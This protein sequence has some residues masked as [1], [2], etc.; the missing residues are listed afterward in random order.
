MPYPVLLG[1]K[2]LKQHNPSV[3]WARGHLSLS[4]CGANHDFPVTAF[5]RGYSLVTPGA[6]SDSPLVGSVGLGQRLNNKPPSVIMKVLAAHRAKAPPPFPN[7]TS[8]NAGSTASILRPPIR[9]GLSRAELKSIWSCPPPPTFGPRNK[10]LHIACV[11][12]Q[13]FRKYAKTQPASLIWYTS[14]DELEVRINALSLPPSSRVDPEM[15]PPEPPP[16]HFDHR[17]A[18]TDAPPAI[19][20][21]DAPPPEPPPIPKLDNRAFIRDTA[22]EVLNLVPEKYHSYLD[23]FDPVEVLKLPEHRPYD[24]AID[25]EEGKTPPFGPIYSLAQDERQILFKYIEEQLQKGYIRRSTSSAASPILFIRRKTGDL[26]L[27]IDYRGLNA[28]TKKNRYPLP[29]TADLLDRVQGCTT[30]TVLDLKNAFNL[31]RIKEGDEWKTAFRTHLGL[32]EYTVMPFGLTNAPA[33][34][35]AFIQDALRDILDISVVVYLDDILIFSRENQDHTALVCQV[36]ERLR[37]ANVFLNAKKCEFDRSQVEYLGFIIS[38]KGVQMNP[39]KLDTISKWPIPKTA[40]QIQQF[41]GFTNFYR[42]FVHRYAEICL[43]LT[44]LTTNECKKSFPGL[45][46]DALAAFEQLKLIFTTAPVLRHFDPTLPST[47]VTDASDYALASVHLQ[48]DSEGLLHPVAYYSRKFAPSEI[49]YEIHDK[50]LLAIVECFRDM[51]SWLVGSPHPITVISDHSNL[52]YFMTTRLLNHRQARWSM[53]L[54]EFDFKLDY[55]PGKNNPADPASRRPDFVPQQGDEV[56]LLQ[57]KALLTDYH[58]ERLF[59]DA[60]STASTPDSRSINALSTFSINNSELLDE[61]KTTYRADTEWRD[62]LSKGDPSITYDNDLVFHNNRLYV[63]QALRAK[64][65]HSCH[66]ALLSGHPGRAGTFDNVQRDYSWPGMRR[67]VRSYV[68]SC[69]LCSRVKNATHKPYGLL[70]PLDIPDRPWRS[71]SMDF[72]TK[73]PLSHGYDSI[74]VVC[75][76]MTRA[77]HFIPINESI[78]APGLARLFL[79]RIFRHHGFPDSIVCD[80]G[81]VFI[82]SFFTH[83][84]K[85]CGTK[86]KAS[87][88]YHPQTDGLTERTNQTL[89][90]YIRAYCSYQ[91]D[92]WVD[93]LALAE[94]S[95]N[96]SKN[97]STQQTPFYANLGYH[98]DF[99][100]RITDRTTNPAATELADRLRLI[101]EEL[102]AEL[103]HSNKYMSKYY[104]RNHLP[105]PQFEPG[106]QVWLLRRNIK[107]TRPTSKLD[108]RRLG[109]FPV[110]ARHNS[111]SYLLDLPR[112]F[113]RLHPVFHVSL[114]EPY[115]PPSIIPDRLSSASVPRVD[116]ITDQPRDIQTIIDCRKVGRRYDYFVH[117]HDE[118]DS[119]NSWIPFSDISTSLYEA[120]EQFHRRNPR[121]PHPPRF[122][123]DPS[124][125]HPIRTPDADL[126]PRSIP[127]STSP[128]LRSPSPPPGPWQRD[129]EPPMQTTTRS[130]RVARPPKSKDYADAILKEGVVS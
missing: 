90:T 66:D 85:L 108:Y 52:R 60:P 13:R 63:P 75:D 105:A 15:P 35:Q 99:E 64:I 81:S 37:A 49:N 7:Y 107:T 4:C 73:L 29:L 11:S 33:T 1:L 83:L 58:T 26:R 39:K 117:W 12:P 109:P 74:W 59:H 31:I 27:C 100:V 51:R 104:D 110:L 14:N 96:N 88:A 54:S 118:P 98:P 22:T 2:W 40:K 38:S 72:I 70:Q 28:I 43:P 6:R 119:E 114:L 50:E 24:I 25:L 21:T 102:R 46:P 94:F 42:R 32:F 91:Q 8:A 10:P 112:S 57:Q 103:K 17:T 95:F 61:F 92:D 106:D 129:Y 53:F 115:T 18:S 77:T 126:A 124:T 121:R 69:D 87:T 56:L 44:N 82:S 65:L 101:H 89:E 76:R 9:N 120:L 79:D 55:A 20:A 86:I 97:S 47:V 122:D 62:L 45:N 130:G 71:I 123:L 113:S 19:A 36:L 78:D 93:Y 127:S 41:L 34:F 48:P 80:R 5:G 67:Y 16:F 30:F 23:V 84:T 128:R 125:H 116:V 111:S 3:D 68:T